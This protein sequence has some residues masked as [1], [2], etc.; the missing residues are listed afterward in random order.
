MALLNFRSAQTSIITVLVA[1]LCLFAVAP[2]SVNEPIAQQQETPYWSSFTGVYHFVS[3]RSHVLIK[4]LDH[5]LQVTSL[6]D[7]YRDIPAAS[8]ALPVMFL[9][10]IQVLLI[11]LLLVPLKYGSTRFV[12]DALDGIRNIP[13]RGNRHDEKR[14][15]REQTDRAN[16]QGFEEFPRVFRAGN[17]GTAG[18]QILPRILT[19]NPPPI[20]AGRIFRLILSSFS[21]F[22][23]RGRPLAHVLQSP[24][25]RGNSPSLPARDGNNLLLCSMGIFL[26]LL[27]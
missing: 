21:I 4:F 2:A 15:T 23:L 10:I 17:R 20:F 8:S 26:V 5:R 12:A 25:S 3:V 16:G 14:R 9:C 11:L 6:P 13:E 24:H 19:A 18:S 22:C 1:C 27:S 7:I